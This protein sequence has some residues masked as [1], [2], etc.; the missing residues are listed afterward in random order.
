[1]SLLYIQIKFLNS[2]YPYI[3][4]RF[5]RMENISQ[6]SM[7]SIQSLRLENSIDQ[8]NVFDSL[9]HIFQD[10]G[11]KSCIYCRNSHDHLREWVLSSSLATPVLHSPIP[12]AP[13]EAQ[14]VAILPIP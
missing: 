5:N 12:D 9:L 7:V 4:P 3:D 6:Y 2:K 1:M 8:L 14:G 13:G 10:Q 11:D